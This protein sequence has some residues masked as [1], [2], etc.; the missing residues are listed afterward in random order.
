MVDE[1]WGGIDRQLVGFA[2]L[3]EAVDPRG[4]LLEQGLGG[5]EQIEADVDRARL[6]SIAKE[7]RLLEIAFQAV[8]LLVDRRLGEVQLFGGL[9]EAVKA[10]GG[11]EATEGT[12]WGSV[13]EHC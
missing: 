4:Q 10:G 11:F 7:Q 8:D 2:M 1:G 12:Q 9:V 3:V 5:A 6:A 13:F